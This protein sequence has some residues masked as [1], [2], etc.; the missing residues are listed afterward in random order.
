MNNIDTCVKDD[1]MIQGLLA[2]IGKRVEVFAFGVT[3]IGELRSVD[4]ENGFV[5]VTDGED[6]VMLEL[7]R[8]ESF[9]IVEG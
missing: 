9:N 7:E 6:T 8:V 5:T 1:P 2:A 3:Y 4:H